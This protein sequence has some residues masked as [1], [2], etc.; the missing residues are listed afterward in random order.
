MAGLAS[1]MMQPARGRQIEAGRHA[2]RLQ[3]ND[4]KA[5]QPR[6]LIGNPKR[7]G[8]P[9]S[10]GDKQAGRVDAVKKAYS[11]RIRIAGF[12]K[13]F[14]G[15]HPK[16]RSRPGF[17]NTPDQRQHERRRRAGVARDGCMDFGKSGA[18][19]PAAERRVETFDTGDEKI[20]ARHSAMPNEIDILGVP[21]KILG[22]TA[23]YPRDFTAQGK[24]SLPRHGGHRHDGT[25]SSNCS[26]YVLIDSR[27]VQ[28]SQA[29]PEENLF[30]ISGYQESCRLILPS[31]SKGL[32]TPASNGYMA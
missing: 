30:L 4:R 31:L 17:D 23:F 19:Q 18:G 12:P 15:S 1:A 2:A 9:V 6:R 11:R 32:E 20:A 27:A 29:Q 22:E 5:I 25:L 28:K 3:K 24:N 10:L 7:V 16:D 26:C 8:Q 14:G 21:A 13:T